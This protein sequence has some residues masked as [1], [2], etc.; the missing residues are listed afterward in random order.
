MISGGGNN[1]FLFSQ[2]VCFY[3][4]E[5]YLSHEKNVPQKETL[6]II[7]LIVS[8][9]VKWSDRRCLVKK[10][11]LTA[12]QKGETMLNHYLY[13]F[14]K[15]L[16][17][18]AANFIKIIK[19]KK[20]CNSVLSGNVYFSIFYWHLSW[21]KAYDNKEALQHFILIN[22]TLNHPIWLNKT[23]TTKIPETGDP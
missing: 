6:L 19:N 11:S 8:L 22:V 2:I 20:L 9:G 23:K 16:N 7:C 15:L 18:E 13:I 21:L 10:V 12:S 14:V 17:E 1:E 4:S 5:L 3:R